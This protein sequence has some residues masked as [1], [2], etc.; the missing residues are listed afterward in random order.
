MEIMDT[1]LEKSN[2]IS[3]AFFDAYANYKGTQN[4]RTL[5][6]GNKIL[7]GQTFPII[8]SLRGRN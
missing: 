2:Q 3:A 1:T 5:E 6:S 7:I 8:A 4:P